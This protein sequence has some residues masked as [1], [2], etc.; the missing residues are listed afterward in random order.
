MKQ[1]AS[2]ACAGDG[3]PQ[4]AA[5]GRKFLVCFG[6]FAVFF[7]FYLGAAMLQTPACKSV[8]M[9]PVCGIPLGLAMSMAIF[10]VSWILI[11]FWFWKAK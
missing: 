1:T 9:T 4:P 3:N 2:P 5:M 11:L 6:T 7:A 10:P 8:A